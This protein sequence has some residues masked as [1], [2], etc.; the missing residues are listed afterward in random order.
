[1][2]VELGHYAL[3]LALVLALVQSVVPIWGTRMGDVRLMETA[4]PLSLMQFMLVSLSFAILM[5]GYIVSDFSIK[6]VWENSHT[7]KP[8]IFKVS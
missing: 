3:I 4:G 7:A 8:L 6:N 2:I 5:H 1:M